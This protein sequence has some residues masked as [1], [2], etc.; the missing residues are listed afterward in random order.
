MDRQE[1]EKLIQN[2]YVQ[3]GAG[4]F[5]EPPTIHV[6]SASSPATKR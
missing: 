6:A 2:L 3:T 5:F 1:L 4:E